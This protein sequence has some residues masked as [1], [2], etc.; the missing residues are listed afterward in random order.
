[1]GAL[2][3]FAVSLMKRMMNVLMPF[4]LRPQACAETTAVRPQAA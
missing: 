3:K 4:Q 2:T 1:M